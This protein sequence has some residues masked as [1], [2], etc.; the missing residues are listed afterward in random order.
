MS[1]KNVLNSFETAVVEQN[2]QLLENAFKKAPASGLSAEEILTALT[3]G[4][5]TVRLSLN[6]HSVS[7][8]EFLLA[9]DVLKEGLDKLAA[10]PSA[11][12]QP[13]KS[14]TIVIGVVEGDIH[15]LGKNIIA[16]V[17]EVSGYTVIDMGKDVSPADFVARLKESGASLLALS[18]M[19]STPLENMKETVAMCKRQFPGVAVIVGGATL[20]EAIAAEYG[21]DGYAESVVTVTREVGR[22][23]EKP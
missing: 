11:K 7:L 6:D 5:D 23:L 19:M 15:E 10:L 16:S 12:N 14:G 9:V 18:T 17:L 8:P 1:E 2:P 13:Q 3:T 20:D 21:A 22:L 4:L